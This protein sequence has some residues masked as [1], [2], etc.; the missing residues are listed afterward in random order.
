MKGW[1]K[2]VRNCLCVLAAA[3]AASG[4]M[5]ARAATARATTMRL[6]KAEGR[7]TLTTVSGSSRRITEAMRLYNGNTLSTGA[8][9]YAY[10]SLD[11]SK[12]VKLDA[13]SKATLR[14]NGNKLEMLLKSGRMFFNV[15]VP[16]KEKESLNVRTSTMV[17]GIRGTSGIV[18]QSG[19]GASTLYLLEG[20]V[21][22]N[23]AGGSVDV[24]G[25]QM[26]TV[27]GNAGELPEAG[28]VQDM[29]VSDIP[30]FAVQEIAADADL[31]EKIE[32]K[33]DLDVDA[34]RD[35]AEENGMD[36]EMP[37]PDQAGSQS[38]LESPSVSGGSGD[39]SGSSGSGSASGQGTPSPDPQDTPDEPDTP[40]VPDKPDV[41]G[42]PGESVK[43]D[44]TDKPD[45][46]DKPAKPDTPDVPDEPDTPDEPGTPGVPDI[47]DMPDVPDPVEP[48]RTLSGDIDEAELSKA[49][50]EAEK[51]Y[52]S[53]DAR[54]T[55]KALAV[56]RGRHLV[57]NAGAD[58]KIE[59]IVYLAEN[60]HLEVGT[61]ASLTAEK[62]TGP[63]NALLSVGGT[64]DVQ[65]GVETSAIA[66]FP[67]GALFSGAKLPETISGCQLL[68][69]I[70]GGAADDAADT[71]IYADH[72]NQAVADRLSKLDSV[73]VTMM[74][75]ADAD[76]DIDLKNSGIY[77]NGKTLKLA[78]GV[79]IRG[80]A[81]AAGSAL[82]YM[83]GGVLEIISG[84]HELSVDSTGAYCIDAGQESCRINVPSGSTAFKALDFEHTF[85]GVTGTE[86]EGSE[87]D[88]PENVNLIGDIVLKYDDGIKSGSATVKGSPV[89]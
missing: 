39:S 37:S 20:K 57:L 81:M 14:Q 9:S 38:Q 22:I 32:S 76:A 63:Q 31:Q 44:D 53:G 77:L 26:L 65:N 82:L 6:E 5:P 78:D 11:S 35:I 85:K 23:C 50:E 47:P 3:L 83:D 40:D 88:L 67:S 84:D 54:Y 66:H 68:C 55:G 58:V 27:S 25:G 69:E 74:V 13:G 1:K 2:T 19:D 56:P 16:L 24:D 51:V 72:A 59:G 52:L 42:K 89:Q 30:L 12:A 61:G 17:T 60:A 43:P 73:K 48:E 28:S 33:T 70:S 7:V 46:P 10:V 45:T 71:Y 62:I 79:D 80:T 21:T 29:A 49:L 8:K 36:V 4:T 75:D 15:K 64:V 18:E 34:I 41:P 87:A 86:V